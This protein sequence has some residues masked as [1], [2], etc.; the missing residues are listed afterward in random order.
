[1]LKK[2]HFEKLGVARMVEFTRG[3]SLVKVVMVIVVL[4]V[5]GNMEKG[6]VYRLFL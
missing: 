5:V 4:V 3:E 1:M 2:R 6:V